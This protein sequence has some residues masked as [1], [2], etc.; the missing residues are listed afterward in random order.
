MREEVRGK[1]GRLRVGILGVAGCMNALLLTDVTYVIIVPSAES[2]PRL[3]CISHF[4]S[5]C[6]INLLFKSPNDSSSPIRF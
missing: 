2:D 4:I 5:C 1:S 3:T 6:F